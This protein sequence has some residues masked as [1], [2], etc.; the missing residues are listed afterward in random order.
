MVQLLLLQTEDLGT[1]IAQKKKNKL[2][3]FKASELS[4]MLNSYLCIG[5][6]GTLLS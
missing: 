1:I 3:H 2:S 4:N 6:N 5:G